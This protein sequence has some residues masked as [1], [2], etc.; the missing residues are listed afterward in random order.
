MSNQ[1][2]IY[3]TADDKMAVEVQFAQDTVWLSQQQMAA[4]FEQTKQNVSLHINNCYKE[5]ELDRI[6]TV[7]E[8]L[9]VQNEGISKVNGNR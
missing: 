1:M 5:G 4:L 3:R 9:T 7:K 2:E 6:S 8:S